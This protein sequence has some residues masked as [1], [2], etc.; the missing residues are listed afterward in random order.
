MSRQ[1]HTNTISCAAAS[2]DKKWLVTGDKG[3]RDTMLVI[4]NA[5][6]GVPVRTIFEPHPGGCIDLDISPDAMYVCTVGA[7]EVQ[8]LAVW[9]WTV[10]REDALAISEI[11]AK[12]TQHCVRFRR[13]DVHEI[14]SNGA[15]RTIFWNW[16]VDDG[17]T[18]DEKGAGA[19][20]GTL[21]FYSPAISAKEFLTPVGN[22]T[23]SVFIPGSTQAVTATEDGDLVLWDQ[24]LLPALHA[25]P[26][27]RCAIKLLKLHEGQAIR[28]VAVFDKFLVT[29]G[30]DG[31]VRFYD[32]KFRLL[33]WYED[34]DVG[35]INRLTFTSS[36][37]PADKL[38][39][40][41]EVR[42]PNFIVSSSNGKIALVNAAVFE[43]FTKEERRAEL[44]VQGIESEISAICAHPAA[45]QVFVT[46]VGAANGSGGML[47]ILDY[48]TQAWLRHKVIEKRRPTCM[49]MN[50]NGQEVM[51]GC[52]DGSLLI[53]A[54]ADLDLIQ[55]A[56]NVEG[57]ATLV[58]MSADG[59]HIAMADAECC[60]GV[61]RRERNVLESG[62]EV[63]WLYLGRYRAHHGAVVGLKF[64][65]DRDAGVVRLLSLGQDRVLVE[66]DLANSFAAT[67]VVV[68]SAV[69]VEQTAVPTAL[70]VLPAG[71]H[72]GEDPVRRLV[73]SAN[74]EYKLKILDA[75]GLNGLH[76]ERPLP[77]QDS[78][79]VQTVLG[80][81]YGMSAL[82]S[83]S[84]LPKHGGNSGENGGSMDAQYCVYTTPE[85]VVGLMRLPLDGNPNSSMGLIAHAGAV[86]GACISYDGSMVLT[87][88][89][90]DYGIMAWQVDTSALDASV[91]LGGS[92]D[93]PYEA[94][95][96]GG[97][98]GEF[99]DE[100]C[101]FFYLAQLRAQGEDSTQERDITGKVPVAMLPDVMRALGYYP[102]NFEI[103]DLTHEVQRKRKDA[104]TLSDL[105][106]LYV[107]HKPVADV[108]L[109]DLGAAFKALG[110]EQITGTLKWE[111]LRLLLLRI[112]EPISDPELAKCLGSLT[113]A[114]VD[115]RQDFSAASFAEQILGF[116]GAGGEEVGGDMLN[117]LSQSMEASIMSDGY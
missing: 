9:D 97:K 83:L 79:C 77:S 86:V 116:E 13:D 70:L 17:N 78:H 27:D 73:V 108:S 107:N 64:V 18:E 68:R 47:R 69:T 25:R 100:M 71:G 53:L 21:K 45:P 32:F 72:P 91:A 41:S 57:A 22:F 63:P 67:G 94:L 59:M 10:E 14:V 51:I 54:T 85:K 76:D 52:S 15:V 110:A 6:T 105:V 20:T 95:I 35:P 81:T 74:N 33:A 66:Y 106:R 19:P 113:D 99:Y 115:G 1:G 5:R 8:S 55:R 104:V 61:Y 62:K 12:D 102:S 34:L 87:T 3:D 65:D 84:M 50:P 103:R 38:A 92:G 90:L 60:V 82:N 117:Q 49:A 46:S 29:A 101:N 44:L 42:V 24:V 28:V 40:E 109:E 30:A 112:G 114:V 56:S 39:V 2:D 58:D 96:P 26:S 43:L 23:Q 48:E 11:T 7:G 75:L 4:W 98:E 88:G 93:E 111:A 36:R 80:P 31:F 37:Q 89:G 16:S